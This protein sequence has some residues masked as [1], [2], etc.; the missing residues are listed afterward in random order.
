MSKFIKWESNSPYKFCPPEQMSLCKDR[1]CNKLTRVD[2]ASEQVSLN[3][4]PTFLNDYGQ[5]LPILQVKRNFP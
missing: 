3:D 1:N 5:M 4:N 2:K